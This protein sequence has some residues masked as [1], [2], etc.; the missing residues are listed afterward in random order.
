MKTPALTIIAAILIPFVFAC[1]AL[2]PQ[3][4][5]GCQEGCFGNRNTAVGDDALSNTTF[6]EDNTALGYHALFSNTSGNDNTAI[7]RGAISSNTVGYHNTAIGFHALRSNTTGFY[8]TAVGS[9]ALYNNIGNGNTATGNI[10]LVSNTTGGYN[11]ATGRVA[12]MNNTTGA[13]N[14]ATGNNALAFNT[15]GNNN[16]AAGPDALLNNT[17]GNDNIALGN[18]AGENLTTGSNNIDI[19][20]QGVADESRTIRIGTNGM[21]DNTY[22]AG[23][24]GATV[25]TGVAVIVYQWTVGTITSSVRYK[26]EVQPMKD[27]SEAILSLRPVT[28]HYKKELDP[29]AIPQFGLVAEDVAKV[30]PDLVAKDEEGKPYTVRYEAVNAM[31][32]NEFLKE[33]KKVEDQASE[34]AELKSTLNS[35]KAR[36]KPSC[37]SLPPD[38]LRVFKAGIGSFATRFAAIAR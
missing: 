12:L 16:V 35:G 20:N 3:A 28:F 22:I 29:N 4:R 21:H 18:N 10:A 5:A 7:G 34:I 27:T 32:L 6:G 36:H 1:F 24:S 23:I 17:T 19:G 11:T 15:T 13:F 14:A 25:P 9:D 26:E 33:H 30:N 37:N 2:A 31:L 8:N 38:S